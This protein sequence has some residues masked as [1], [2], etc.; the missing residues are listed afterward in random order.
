M[1]KLLA[2]SL[3]SLLNK[4]GIITPN[5]VVQRMNDIEYGDALALRQL[6]RSCYFQHCQDSS[7]PAQFSELQADY[8]ASH[9]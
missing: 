5:R 7:L 4:M 8:L 6:R 9:S 1:D 3:N 2:V